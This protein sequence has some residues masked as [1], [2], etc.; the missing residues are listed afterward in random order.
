MRTYLNDSD[1]TLSV[2]LLDDSGGSLSFIPTAVSY[3]ILNQEGLEVLPP[4]N[5]AGYLGESSVNIFVSAA[6]NHIK[7]GLTRDV[8]LIELRCSAVNEFAIVRE[9]YFIE[10]VNALETGINSYQSLQSAEL[11]S[12]EIANLTGWQ[13]ASRQEKITALQEARERV[14]KMSLHPYRGDYISQTRVMEPFVIDG[15]FADGAYGG[16]NGLSAERF[17][18]LPP[19]FVKAIRKA[20]IA[21]A[22]YILEGDSV[23]SKERSGITSEKIGESMQTFKVAKKLQY[24]ICS[25]AIMYIST[26]IVRSKKLGRS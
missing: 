13:S 21:E 25:A 11:I 20:Q 24:P 7:A 12:S 10:T 1:A 14:G 17:L 16:L 9:N 19:G 26:Y 18:S 22:N 3:R 4:T 2:E 5:I 15:V 8:R 23:E 6:I